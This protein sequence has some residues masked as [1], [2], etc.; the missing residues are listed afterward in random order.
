[1]HILMPIIKLFCEVSLILP[2]VIR[3]FKVFFYLI[4]NNGSSL[5]FSFIFLL[6]LRWILIFL[7]LSHICAFSVFVNYLFMTS[8]CFTLGSVLIYLS[9]FYQVIDV[10]PTF[11]LILRISVDNL[12]DFM[13]DML[14]ECESFV[15]L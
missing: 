4:E 11:A 5:L 7:H 8:T 14:R 3:I 6:L 12:G 15:C 10:V 2:L 13:F 9:D 1:M